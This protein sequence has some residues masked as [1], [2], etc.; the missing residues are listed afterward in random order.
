MVKNSEVLSLG[1]VDN[2]PAVPEAIADLLLGEK[3]PVKVLWTA[4]TGEQTLEILNSPS[5]QPQIV[6]T[7]MSM[8]SMSGCDL[9]VQIWNHFADIG[10]IGM[11]A[12]QVNTNLLPVKEGESLIVVNKDIPTVELVHKLGEVSHCERALFWDGGSASR[13]TL[14]YME[15]QIM[16]LSAKGRTNEAI[17]HQIGIS[18]QSVKTYVKRAYVKLEAHSR[19]EA[20]V[21]CIREGIIR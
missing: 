1:I 11:T 8:P 2:D 18:V 21:A 15:V 9:A 10:V 3:A 16:R 6:L 14:S 5:L 4:R 7:D 12:F 17:A 13:S 20:L 19:A